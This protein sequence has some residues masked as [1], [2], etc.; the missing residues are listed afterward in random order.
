[1][2]SVLIAMRKGNA[3]RRRRTVLLS[4]EELRKAEKLRQ[5]EIR[6]IRKALM[7]GNPIGRATR[8]RDEQAAKDIRRNQFLSFEMEKIYWE[9]NQM[10][11]QD[12]DA[13]TDR[14]GL[15][16]EVW[17]KGPEDEKRITTFSLIKSRMGL[18]G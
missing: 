10:D 15:W 1:M 13:T 5:A 9:R 6:D 11:A 2:D 14:E 8:E 3:E 16:V 7:I 17:P 12:F 4:K 18:K